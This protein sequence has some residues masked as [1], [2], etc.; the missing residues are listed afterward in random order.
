MTFITNS[1]RRALDSRRPSDRII[2]INQRMRALNLCSSN[3]ELANRITTLMK[4]NLDQAE[5]LLPQAPA[6]NPPIAPTPQ[7]SIATEYDSDSDDETVYHD[8]PET[9]A[10]QAALPDPDS[11]SAQPQPSARVGFSS[12]TRGRV[13]ARASFIDD[14]KITIDGKEFYLQL[15]ITKNGVTKYTTLSEAQKEAIIQQIKDICSKQSLTIATLKKLRI[16]Y[17]LKKDSEEIDFNKNPKTTYRI[18][19]DAQDKTIDTIVDSAKPDFEK[20]AKMFQDCTFTPKP[21]TTSSTRTSPP[22]SSQQPQPRGIPNSGNNCCINSAMQELIANPEVKAFFTSD[23]TDENTIDPAKRELFRAIKAFINQYE[24]TGTEANSEAIRI[25]LP[26]ADFTDKY[27]GDGKPKQLDAM[28]IIEYIY[29]MLPDTINPQGLHKKYYVSTTD[30]I[31]PQERTEHVKGA[32]HIPATVQS[33]F[34]RRSLSFEQIVNRTFD[35]APLVPAELA[36]L[37]V[38]SQMHPFKLTKEQIIYTEIPTTLNIQVKRP[39]GTNQVTMNISDK[40]KIIIPKNPTEQHPAQKYELKSFICHEGETGQGGHYKSYVKV[41]ETWFE[42]N[43]ATVE[44]ITDE[45]AK[46][47]MTIANRLSFRKV[48]A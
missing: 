25:A 9:E 47:L 27:D 41:N 38:N 2:A 19:G 1:I 37:E 11:S 4:T 13:T 48:S 6:A 42:C 17:Q 26:D 35:G 15:T 31:A 18:N 8:A 23:T 44:S 20:L 5:A 45:R 22:Q 24:T 46:E 40:I 14:R 12:A 10:A 21:S 28:N 29:E 34:F 43:D 7:P 16:N 39:A 33:G 30:G 32:L 3:P 36:Q